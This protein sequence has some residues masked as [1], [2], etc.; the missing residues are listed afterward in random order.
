ML[1]YH[2]AIIDPRGDGFSGP[3]IGAFCSTLEIAHEEAQIE[4]VSNERRSVR[5]EACN[6]NCFKS[7]RK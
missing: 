4:K 5:I 3:R 7:R 6:R 1:H 2:I